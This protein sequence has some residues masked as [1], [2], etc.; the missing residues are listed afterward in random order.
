MPRDEFHQLWAL[1]PG[2]FV[3]NL[4]G[5]EFGFQLHCIFADEALGLGT[6]EASAFFSYYVACFYQSIGPDGKI[7]VHLPTLSQ[8]KLEAANVVRT[9]HNYNR[10]ITDGP[11]PEGRATI[12]EFDH[13]RFLVDR[14]PLITLSG[15]ELKDPR[16]PKWVGKWDLNGKGFWLFPPGK[17]QS[18][19][20][21]ASASLRKQ[22][23]SIYR[24]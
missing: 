11:N 12:V 9:W 19:P 4:P 24:Q 16:V 23:Q 22:I 10:V 14:C 7:K 6:E 3:M 13:D 2:W 20:D 18:V 8:A 1:K 17:Q 5:S 21:K 15:L